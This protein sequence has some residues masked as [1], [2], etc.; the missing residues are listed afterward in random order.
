[1]NMGSLVE[2]LEDPAMRFRHRGGQDDFEEEDMLFG[3]TPKVPYL[4]AMLVW[5]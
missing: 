1:M 3:S 2:Q 5:T 4:P